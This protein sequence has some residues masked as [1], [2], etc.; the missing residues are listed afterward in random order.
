MPST[1]QFTSQVSIVGL[2]LG[3]AFLFTPFL[4]LGW[5]GRKW[6]GLAVML[7][8][9]PLLFIWFVLA[10]AWGVAE[11]GIVPGH[12]WPFGMIPGL[13]PLG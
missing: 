7:A 8:L 11:H 1:V 4:I 2:I 12:S 5:I 6:G 13:L 10:Q 3:V 9:F